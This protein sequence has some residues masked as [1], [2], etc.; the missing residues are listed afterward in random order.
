MSDEDALLAAIIAHP[1]EDTPRLMYADWLEEHDWPDR[2]EFIRTQIER[3]RLPRDDPRRQPL[4]WREAEL[5]VEAQETWLRPYLL[6]TGGYQG[7]FIRRG[8]V[9]V[10]QTSADP[11][12]AHLAVLPELTALLELRLD[13]QLVGADADR[14]GFAV[15]AP[16]TGTQGWFGRMRRAV[17][18]LVT[19][20]AEQ[21]PPDAPDPLLDPLCQICLAGRAPGLRIRVILAR[22]YAPP[23]ETYY[24]PPEEAYWGIELLPRSP[25]AMEPL[26]LRGEWTVLACADG[27]PDEWLAVRLLVRSLGELPRRDREALFRQQIGIRAIGARPES[28][29]WCPQMRLGPGPHWL[30][31]KGGRL[32]DQH[33]GSDSPPWWIE[34]LS[35]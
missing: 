14:E 30:R 2:A 35:W 15:P 23:D 31:L 24:P 13:Y 28:V 10:L 18:W 12:A 8:I 22:D 32:V 4:L 3:A 26:L 21:P 27:A 34:G 19:G 6:L 16:A 9:E 25:V 20:P 17:T 7:L 1:D 33:S 5:L 11:V 29:A